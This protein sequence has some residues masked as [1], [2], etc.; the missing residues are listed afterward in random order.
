[1]NEVILKRTFLTKPLNS[2]GMLV[3]VALFFEGFS[4]AT[5]FSFKIE[6]V[7][8][9]GGGMAYAGM[10]LKN[11]LMPEACTLLILVAVINLY[12]KLL[13]LHT[14]ELN[15]RSLVR[16]QL[17]MLP[18]FCV[19]FFIFNPFTQTVRFLLESFPQYTG[20]NYWQEAIL[21][22]YTFRIYILYLMPI[23]LLGYLAVNTS[24]VM[25]YMAQ[26]ATVEQALHLTANQSALLKQPTVA[27]APVP[28]QPVYLSTLKGRN[29]NAQY[30]ETLITT[31]EC[32]CFLKEDR[33]YFAV[34]DSGRFGILKTLNE[35]EAEL[36]PTLFFRVNRGVIINR[37]TVLGISH[38]KQGKYL[39]NLNCPCFSSLVLPRTRL[40]EFRAWLA[41]Y[42]ASP[43]PGNHPFDD[44]QLIPSMMDKPM[45]LQMMPDMQAVLH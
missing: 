38:W 10:W 31:S 43:L 7:Q 17:V 24:L 37:S 30:G 32:C 19:A 18:L 45:P 36:D 44:E 27:V 2:I 16:Y 25:D 20:K 26:Q 3:G 8:A 22:S 34:Q 40:A 9:F 41:G 23:T 39:I 42:P 14:L 33:T 6:R 1:M 28:G 12:H 5:A 4:W 11:I 13:R 15:W 21:N 35:L 29:Q